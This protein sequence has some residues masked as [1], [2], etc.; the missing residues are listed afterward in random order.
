MERNN[1]I[2]LG[3]YMINKKYSIKEFADK[4]T[5][6]IVHMQVNSIASIPAMIGII[7]L[8]KLDFKK[9]LVSNVTSLCLLMYFTVFKLQI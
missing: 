5:S 4:Y 9:S 7:H 6:I 2:Y 1:F 8:V 3:H